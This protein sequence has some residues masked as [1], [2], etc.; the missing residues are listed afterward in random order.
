MQEEDSGFVY[1]Y[2]KRSSQRAA[3]CTNIS[4][5]HNLAILHGCNLPFTCSA[6]KVAGAFFGK[7]EG[8]LLWKKINDLAARLVYELR[9]ATSEKP[10][11]AG[12]LS[13]G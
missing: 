8:K 12:P 4:I 3:A 5:T 6:E 2:I 11:P 9:L 10:L 1:M 13:T 7:K